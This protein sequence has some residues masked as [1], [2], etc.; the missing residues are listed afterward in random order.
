MRPKRRDLIRCLIINYL[1]AAQCSDTTIC[2]ISPWSVSSELQMCSTRTST[3]SWVLTGVRLRKR[4]KKRTL[5]WQSST[6]QMSTRLLR[7]RTSLP[8]STQLTRR[9]ATSKR[10]GYMTQQGLTE[11][12]KTQMRRR[13]TSMLRAL[14]LAL[15]IKSSPKVVFLTTMKKCLE[16]ARMV[17]R[18]ERRE[19]LCR[20][21]DRTLF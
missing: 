2:F 1:I 14:P 12:S 9:S 11:T 18:K 5:V 20:P 21:R 17:G 3:A 19:K 4:L 10:D 8:K 13:T 7:R 6:I 15:V 16:Q